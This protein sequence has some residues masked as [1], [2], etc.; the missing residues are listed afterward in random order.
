M[1]FDTIEAAQA[2][3]IEALRAVAAAMVVLTHYLPLAGVPPGAWG[4]ASTGV[5]LF[6]VLSGFVFAPYLKRPGFALAPHV[7]RRLFRLFPLYL[8]ALLAYALLKP[9]PIRWDAMA[10]HVL[11][12]HTLGTLELA[13]FYNVAFWSLPPEVEFYLALPVLAWLA[14]RIRLRGLLL[15]GLAAHLALALAAQAGES[16][17]SARSL[18]TVHLPGLLL[19]FMFGAAVA[20][21][22]AAW[23]T[24]RCRIV[25]GCVAAGAG[26]ALLLAWHAAL[27][28][29]G[30]T[31]LP[32]ALAASVGAW[33]ALVY[34]LALHALLPG[35]QPPGQIAVGPTR[36]A[37]WR[38]ALRRIALA[39]GALSYGVYLLH[40]AAP[41]ALQRTWP[42]LQGADLVL[43]SVALTLVAAA[44]AHR[45]VESPLRSFGREL[46]LRLTR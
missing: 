14:A 15:L 6:F 26:L 12:L 18:A 17:E 11:M 27:R 32:P 43:S 35:P 37:F 3:R 7:V 8:L 4:L 31:G 22:P 29:D 2:A 10:A 34:G 24:G 41:L 39:L 13:A 33:A 19:Q 1:T 38:G 16:P 44:L 42:S 28:P 23:R 25:S 5:N 46:A 30:S 40:N 36:P 45:L 9:E 20:L 21:A